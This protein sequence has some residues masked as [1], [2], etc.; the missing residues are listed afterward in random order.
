MERKS[1]IEKDTLSDYPAKVR[2][3]AQEDKVP[4]I[5][6]HA[7]SRRLYQAMKND[8]DKAFQDGTHHTSYGSYQLAKCV[9]QGIRESQPD[10]AKYIVDDFKGF[11]PQK[12]DPADHFDIPAS[13]MK[14]PLAPLGS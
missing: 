5:D 11:D 13:P 10:L 8:L 7:M 2:E 6:L 14:T 9:V 3:L 12:P 4:L 1:G